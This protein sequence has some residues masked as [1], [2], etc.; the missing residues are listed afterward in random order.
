MIMIMKKIV[1][2]L[3]FVAIS[4]CAVDTRET[5]SGSETRTVS[6]DQR[7]VVVFLG[8]SLTAGLGLTDDQAYPALI[9]AK[10]DS[11]DFDYRVINAGE[12]GSTSAGGLRRIEWL[13]RSRIDVLVVELGANDGLRGQDVD[14][15]KTN[16]AEIIEKTRAVYPD[17]R[18]VL[19]GM[20]APPNFGGDYTESFRNVF[21]TLAAEADIPLVPFLL[22][23]V[24]GVESLNQ[25]DGI[26]PTARGQQIVADN[27]WE[28]LR[29]ELE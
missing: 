8:T 5:D 3:G 14:A 13:L 25:P 17:V 19:A 28:V 21:P 23:G 1:W 10:I 29:G 15:M 6:R 18:V 24:A 9:Q 26:H 2:L 12:S 7:A 16:I 27:V 20:E 11:A 4:S 22:E